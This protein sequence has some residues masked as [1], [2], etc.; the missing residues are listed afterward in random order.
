MRMGP[1]GPFFPHHQSTLE[2]RI[3]DMNRRMTQRID[4][5]NEQE[6]QWW[7]VFGNEFFD[8]SARLFL[9]FHLDDGPKKYSIGRT[10]IPRYFRSI[11]DGGVKDLFYV[12]R[13]PCREFMA[14]ADTLVLEV[15]NAI[16]VTRHDKPQYT[17]V[18]T[19]GRLY[20][21][22]SLSE[23]YANFPPRVRLWVFEI[24]NHQ[25][26]VHRN[27]LASLASQQ[28]LA[29][30]ATESLGKDITR[31]GIT[32]VTLNYLRLCM[33]LEPM[34]NLMSIHKTHNVPPADCLHHSNFQ[35]HAAAAAQSRPRGAGPGPPGPP[36]PIS[37]PILA[38]LPEPEP[39]RPAP[40][41]RKRNRKGSNSGPGAGG[42][43]GKAGAGPVPNPPTASPAPGP[44]PPNFAL[45]SHVDVMVVGEPSLM[46]GDFGDE[47]ERMISR[48]ENT[49]FDPSLAPP[50]P[51]AGAMW[52]GAPPPPPPPPQQQHPGHPLPHPGPLPTLPPPSSHSPSLSRLIK[53]EGG[54][55]PTQTPP[56]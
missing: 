50:P 56:A 1:P 15:E 37:Q 6:A 36:P 11:F 51:E 52:R 38:P 34:Q 43:K 16:Q 7:D 55:H 44:P 53:A 42:K 40:P 22:F 14:R 2:Q 39:Q 25:E 27:V 18:N 29:A 12:L 5:K 9:N 10:L 31:Q 49:Q 46:G 26:F 23:E 30:E 17:E 41:K 19:E 24:R 47:D 33:I 13:S 4:S 8:D 45:T 54:D 20:V 21:E 28:G 48:M 35:R 3:Y 32:P